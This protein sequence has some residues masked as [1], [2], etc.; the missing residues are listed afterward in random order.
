MFF[1]NLRAFSDLCCL[2]ISAAL[3]R[4][5]SFFSRYAVLY[6]TADLIV[7][8]SGLSGRHACV[9]T[10]PVLKSDAFE[11]RKWKQTNS[12]KYRMGVVKTNVKKDKYWLYSH[13]Y[14]EVIFFYPH[15][16]RST[17]HIL[18]HNGSF[19]LDRVF[20]NFF[21]LPSPESPWWLLQ[22]FYPA[23][24]HLGDWVLLSPRFPPI[25]GPFLRT[26]LKFEI[27]VL[28]L[29]KVPTFVQLFQLPSRLGPLSRL[30]EPKLAVQR[31]SHHW[32][33]SLSSTVGTREIILYSDDTHTPCCAMLAPFHFDAGKSLRAPFTHRQSLVWR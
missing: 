29:P 31:G 24:D 21:S 33:I 1:N 20:V 27:F 2:L 13:V 18:R 10:C 12:N 9:H 14:S 19:P 16:S 3:L 28:K 17:L 8:L 6:R 22:F 7:Y 11:F 4:A 26:I 25:R 5:S 15:I 23:P 32:L 30:Y